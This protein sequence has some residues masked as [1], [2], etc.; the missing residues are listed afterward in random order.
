[1]PPFP[2]MRNKV[3]PRC[4]GHIKIRPRRLLGLGPRKL[5]HLSF[6][7]LALAVCGDIFYG[8]LDVPLDIEGVARRLWNRQA[9]VQREATRHSSKSAQ[10]FMSVICPTRI[11]R[12]SQGLKLSFA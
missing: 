9:E 11:L 6:A 8:L 1:M 3:G 5:I 4:L 7:P 12:S 10:V 2:I